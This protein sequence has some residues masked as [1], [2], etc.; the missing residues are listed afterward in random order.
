[1]F[2]IV[3]RVECLSTSEKVEQRET[4][5]HEGDRRPH[6]ILDR[7]RRHSGHARHHLLLLLVRNVQPIR[8]CLNSQWHTL[9]VASLQLAQK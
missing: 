3:L 1:M 8:L 4:N 9:G 5:K 2:R 6:G 7:R